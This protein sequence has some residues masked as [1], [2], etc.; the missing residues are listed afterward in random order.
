MEQ[1]DQQQKRNWG[2]RRV[3][4]KGPKYLSFPIQASFPNGMTAGVCHKTALGAALGWRRQGGEIRNKMSALGSASSFGHRKQHCLWEEIE[5]DSGPFILQSNRNHEP[6]IALRFHQSTARYSL[7]ILLS[8]EADT[9]F[10]PYWERT[11]GR[12]NV[13][14]CGVSGV[15]P[16]SN[17]L[18]GPSPFHISL[19]SEQQ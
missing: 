13:T 12:S 19:L 2:Q 3:I 10:L 8:Q 11:S 7:F 9:A 5:W 18:G 16:T 4:N 1:R 17:S 15:M 6:W 14:F